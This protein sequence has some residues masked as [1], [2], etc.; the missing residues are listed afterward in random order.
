MS[1]NNQLQPLDYQQQSQKLS[2]ICKQDKKPSYDVTVF[3]EDRSIPVSKVFAVIRSVWGDR[4]CAHL[5]EPEQR[6]MATK[7]W[8]KGLIDLTDEQIRKAVNKLSTTC[9]F[10]PT[11]AQFR[12]A[13]FGIIPARQAYRRWA[14]KDREGLIGVAGDCFTS[15]DLSH[16]ST[17]EI[18]E[19]YISNYNCVVDDVLELV[20]N[21]ED[22]QG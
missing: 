9:E 22:D 16:M 13:A 17:K 1:V 10:A 5:V 19:T 15:W 11:L 2:E 7:M 3:D 21:W 8:S 20:D 12:K 18:E 4:W 6:A 14:G